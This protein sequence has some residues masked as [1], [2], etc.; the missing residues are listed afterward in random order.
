MKSLV[1]TTL[2]IF[3]IL[4]ISAQSKINNRIFFYQDTTFLT[5]EYEMSILVIKDSLIFEFK[6][7][8]ME[9]DHCYE[10]TNNYTTNPNKRVKLFF[11]DYSNSLDTLINSVNGEPA[12][13]KYKTHQCDDHLLID[14][15]KQNREY[16]LVRQFILLDESFC[17]IYFDSNTKRISKLNFYQEF[18]NTYSTKKIL[19][20]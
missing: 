4:F 17:E 18:N 13:Y 8:S 10:F 11:K 15:K 20:L 2:L 14:L 6:I 12:I 9:D 7:C 3:N 5:G 19:K 1:F 16:V